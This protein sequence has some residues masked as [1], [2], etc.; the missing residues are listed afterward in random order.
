MLPAKLMA[1]L[2][3]LFR[4]RSDTFKNAIVSNE[5]SLRQLGLLRLNRK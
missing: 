1:T 3:D 2:G 4:I 5:V